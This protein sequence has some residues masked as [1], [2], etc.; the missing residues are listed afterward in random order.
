MALAAPLRPVVLSF[1][2]ELTRY[3]IQAAVGNYVSEAVTTRHYKE[4]RIHVYAV[5]NGSSN[6]V[7]EQLIEAVVTLQQSVDG[8]GWETMYTI[9]NPNENGEMV[10][11]DPAPLTRALISGYPTENFDL[12]A[13]INVALQEA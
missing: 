2:P 3:L 12:S 11:L 13:G 1:T 10:V 7:G 4:V 8:N 9:T 6:T 5:P